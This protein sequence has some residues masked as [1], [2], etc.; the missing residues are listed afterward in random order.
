MSKK[1]N[2]VSVTKLQQTTQ[3]EPFMTPNIGLSAALVCA[4]H[5]I[6][7]LDPQ[8][9]VFVFHHTNDL[10]RDVNAYWQDTLTVPAHSYCHTMENLME[11]RMEM[12]DSD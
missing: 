1:I 3:E 9:G 5:K 7:D 11:D 6:K 12:L 2:A 8:N 4:G 10:D